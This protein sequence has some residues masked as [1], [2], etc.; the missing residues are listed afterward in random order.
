[1]ITIP[2]CSQDHHRGLTWRSDRQPWTVGLKESLVTNTGIFPVY[3]WV[4]KAMCRCDG[5]YVCVIV[6]VRITDP[7]RETLL[8]SGKHNCE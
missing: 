2:S 3:G 1:M 5:P 7:Q 8:T 4:W 6:S